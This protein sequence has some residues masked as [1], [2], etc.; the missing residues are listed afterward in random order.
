MNKSNFVG[1]VK[2]IEHVSGR[3]RTLKKEEMPFCVPSPMI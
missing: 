1:I 3:A 2:V